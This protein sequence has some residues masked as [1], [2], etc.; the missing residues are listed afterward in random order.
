[1]TKRTL[2]IIGQN[3]PSF[4]KDCADYFTEILH[5][6]VLEMLNTS[7][8]GRDSINHVLF[9]PDSNLLSQY[10]VKSKEDQLCTLKNRLAEIIDKVEFL[11][12]SPILNYDSLLESSLYSH[13]I[14]FANSEIL[15]AFFSNR[16]NFIYVPENKEDY[17]NR[18]TLRMLLVLNTKITSNHAKSIAEKNFLYSYSTNDPVKAIVIDADN[19]L[20]AGIASELELEQIVIGGHS[21]EGD[22]YLLIHRQLISLVNRGFLLIICSK[23]NYDST[24]NVLRKH[25]ESLLKEDHFI[26]INCSWSEKSSVI[27]G[28]SERLNLRIESILF[29]DDS[30]H[31]ID[32]VSTNLPSIKTLHLNS[33]IYSR[34]KQIS[35]S[36]FLTGDFPTNESKR[37]TKLY[38]ENLSRNKHRELLESSGSNYLKWLE[39]LNTLVTIRKP[40]NPY[41]NQRIRQ[42]LIRSKQFNTNPNFLQNS[43]NLDQDSVYTLDLS[44]IHGSLGLIGVLITTTNNSNFHLSQSVLSCR[45]FSRDIEYVL[46]N[47]ALCKWKESKIP[48]FMIEFDKILPQE[49][50]SY[51]FFS[52]NNFPLNTLLTHKDIQKL[53]FKEPSHIQIKYE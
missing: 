15:A 28:I 33:D 41:K 13:R 47:L 32:E 6:P 46:I 3:H 42:L 11:L 31:E 12:F 53:N 49:T 20:W 30:M 21:I 34:P 17:F 22:L 19:T 36:I 7:D 43:S 24:I 18:S 40:V 5:Y 8:L 26:E 29:V 39:S 37:R 45:A 1:M 10:Y 9:L 25:P 51:K 27:K 52:S 35:E 44:D 48:K 4:S 38:E 2:L 23:S 50:Y 16:P 14:H